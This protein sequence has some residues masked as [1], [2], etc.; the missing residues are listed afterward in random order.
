MKGRNRQ[1]SSKLAL[2]SSRWFL[3][4]AWLLSGPWLMAHGDLHGQIEE[5]TPQILQQPGQGEL[6]FKRAE[7]HR[8]HGSLEA[9]EADYERA[10][11]LAPTLSGLAFGRGQAFLAAGKLGKALE[12]FDRF[13]L[14]H[15]G[16]VPAYVAR[17]KTRFRAKAFLPAA[18]DY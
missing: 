18:A 10:G 4:C 15:P 7:L 17:A 9:A 2:L 12:A 8:A 16:H 5:L 6:Y 14:A 13:L 11:Q 3:A 1:C